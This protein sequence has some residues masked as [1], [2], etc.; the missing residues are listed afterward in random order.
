[1]PAPT[2]A[3]LPHET[4]LELRLVLTEHAAVVIEEAERLA[5]DPS[6]PGGAMITPTLIRDAHTWK[7]RGYTRP[8]KSKKQ[9][10]TTGLLFFIAFIGGVFVNNIAKSWG[11]IGFACCAAAALATFIVG[12]QDD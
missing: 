8:V 10:V 1:M 4:R 5:A 2:S 3:G 6:R 12:G 11:A 7:I 9:Q